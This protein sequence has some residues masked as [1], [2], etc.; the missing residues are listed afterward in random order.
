MKP[1]SPYIQFSCFVVLL[2]MSGI[3]GGCG[4][5]PLTRNYEEILIDS[6]E[7]KRSDETDPNSFMQGM[8]NDDIHSKLRSSSSDMQQIQQAE[9]NPQANKGEMPND[10]VH[11]KLNMDKMTLSQP[12]MDS[13]APA[14]LGW[15]TPSGWNEVKG[16]GMRLVTFTT[17]DKEF[18]IETSIVSLA[19]PAGGISANITRWIKQLNLPDPSS[20]EL[21][22][23]MNRQEKIKALGLTVQLVDFTQW[24]K[25]APPQTPS[26]MAAILEQENSKIFVKMTG[27]KSGILKNTDSFKS[28]IQ[29]LH[30]T[31][32]Q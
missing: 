27:A 4:Q 12:I 13:V 6:K 11:A 19:G 18:P 28:L 10:D 16:D 17:L 2:F 26:M 30:F 14:P 1:K 5:P 25:D 9:S 3:S 15:S 29:S 32:T 23:F 21:D 22:D 8:P 31:D 20:K 24:Q 7:P